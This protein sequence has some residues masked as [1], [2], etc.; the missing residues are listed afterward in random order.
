MKVIVALLRFYSNLN[1]LDSIQS[2][3]DSVAKSICLFLGYEYQTT[4]QTK[5]NFELIS[6]FIR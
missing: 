1:S 3:P 4:R 2:S 6:Y 5:N